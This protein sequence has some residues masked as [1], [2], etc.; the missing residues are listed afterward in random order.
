MSTKT[1][2][3]QEKKTMKEF[4][5]YEFSINTQQLVTMALLVAL[6]I[7]LSRFGSINLWN[8]RIG[9]GFV[10]I[11]VAGMLLGPTKAALTAGVADII[12]ALLVPTGAFFPGLTVTAVLR[13][14]LY[15]VLLKLIPEMTAKN[16]GIASFFTAPEGLSAKYRKNWLLLAAG[17]VLIDQL[18]LGLLLQSYWLSVLFGSPYGGMLVSRIPQIAILI[19]VEFVV[20]VFLPRLTERLKPMLKGHKKRK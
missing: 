19:P 6:D 16:Q 7:V 2:S 17:T 14:V 8:T 20:L 1:D 5:K 3:T 4:W 11:V 10:P 18:L 15:G 12:G 13:G 9:F